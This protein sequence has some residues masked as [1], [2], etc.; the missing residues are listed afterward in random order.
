MFRTIATAL[1]VSVALAFCH[2]ANAVTEDDLKELREQVRQLKLDY[3]TRI[4]ALEQRLKRAEAAAGKA[5]ATAR[6]ADAAASKAEAAATQA[7]SQ[8]SN[9][10]TGENAMNPGISL[11][12]NG[13]YSNLSQDPD[14][15]R[16]NGFIP[17]TGDVAPAKRGLSLGDSELVFAANVDH[18]FRGT[19]IASVSPDS[20]SAAIEE[21]YIETLGLTSGFTLKA[22]RFLSSVGYQNSIHPHAWDFADAS[23]AS[24]VFL[25]GQLAEDG[26]H[27]KWVAPTDLYLDMGA[28]IGRGRSFPGA[29]E[30]GRNKNGIGSGVAFM[31]LGGDIGT[32]TA[33]QLGLSHLQT[34]PRDRSYTDMDALGATVTNSYSG[35]TRLWVLDGVLKWAPN[36]NSTYTNFK[37]Q[38]EYFRR[39]EDGSLTYDTTASSRGPRTGAYASQQSGW[40]A[41]GVYQFVPRWRVGYR[42]DRLDSGAAGLGLVA[43]GAL[44]ASDFPVL[45]RYSPN[46]N[47]LMLDWTPSEFSR[48]RLQ[49][50]R[51]ESRLGATDNQVMLQYIMSLGAHGAHNF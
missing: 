16:I 8:A 38:G 32:G 50:A 7:A 20:N 13:T 49:L 3:E 36:G 43:S 2:A 4:E 41:Q 9:R 31:H 39:N 6:G 46:R 51:D 30:G 21:G 23:L 28:E 48:V 5:E 35:N 22:G 45:A 29:P 40:Y 11:I 24:N 10:P 37:L 27:L 1:A 34:S 18:L 17:P 12:L 26:V 14:R 42:Y 47:T 25:G 15:Y 19:L 33:W 44:A